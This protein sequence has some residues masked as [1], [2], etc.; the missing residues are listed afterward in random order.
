MGVIRKESFMSFHVLALAEHPLSHIY[1][2]ETFL[3][4]F[5]SAKYLPTDFP[6]NP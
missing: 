6:K 3:H 2:S 4:K 1:F 5:A